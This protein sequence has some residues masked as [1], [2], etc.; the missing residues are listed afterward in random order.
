V[1]TTSINSRDPDLPIKSLPGPLI[2]PRAVSHIGLHR[3]AMEKEVKMKLR[4]STSESKIEK[5][6]RNE[7][8]AN[9]AR[10]VHFDANGAESKLIISY[11]LIAYCARSTSC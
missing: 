3:V 7:E 4:R 5:N 9:K 1:S 8:R 6:K 10:S 11:Y 2:P